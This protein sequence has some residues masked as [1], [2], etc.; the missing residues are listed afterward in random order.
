MKGK[1]PYY[2]DHVGGPGQKK[3]AGKPLQRGSLPRRLSL[4]GKGT[5]NEEGRSL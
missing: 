5:D 4:T 2:G 3:A 1:E